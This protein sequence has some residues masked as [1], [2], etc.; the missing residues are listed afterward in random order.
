MPKS[1]AADLAAAKSGPV[2]QRSSVVPELS[3]QNIGLPGWS[4]IMP[5][6]RELNE[7]WVGH[8]RIETVEDMLNHYQVAA[9]RQ[10]VRLP[11][12][13]YIIE[14]DPQDCDQVAADLIATDLDVPLLGSDERRTGRRAG[15]FSQRRH[16]DRALDALDYGH[17]VFEHTG[18]Y[19]QAGYWRLTDLPP[20]PQWTISDQN[21]WEIDRHGRLVRVVQLGANPPVKLKTDRLVVFT[22]QG[23]PGDPRGRS[24]LRPL[25]VAWNI[26]S[27]LVRVMGMSG[28]RTGMGIPVG[29]VSTSHVAGAKEKMES[30]LAGLAAGH[31][32]NL[33]L[34]SDE[35]ITKSVMLMGVTG[36]TP[37][38]V[39]MLRYLDEVMARAMLAMLLQLGQTETG[40]RA[41]GGTFDDILAMF[42]DTVVDWYCDNLTEQLV[43]PWVD[44]NRGEDA[45][46]PRLVWRRRDDEPD[47]EPR[48]NDSVIPSS[49]EEITERQLPAPVAARA[50]RPVA[51]DAP[52]PIHVGDSVR[53]AR[54]D[55]SLGRAGT[56]AAQHASVP[57]G[58][59]RYDVVWEDGTRS[60]DVREF[61]LR[62]LDQPASLAADLC[63]VCQGDLRH[64]PHTHAGAV[65]SAAQGE[66][67]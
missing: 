14:L 31:D 28:E 5:A 60:N 8:Q 17:A 66:V 50:R 47:D 6:E 35:D 59:W 61:E 26:S 11:A 3:G 33:V 7:L 63:P 54:D 55:L 58:A 36:S 13:R 2:T 39:G 57:D 49:A 18:Y 15:R 12:H 29:K 45:P 38:I 46:A 56:V 65:I 19:D 32:T 62:R 27:R 10:V 16:F 30:L 41:L 23:R 34:E 37:D 21:S 64:G 4:A 24:M 22:W 48:Q 51:L 25:T 67:R 53:E 1:L 9:L 42:H 44:R 40:S 20:V 43:E 52:V